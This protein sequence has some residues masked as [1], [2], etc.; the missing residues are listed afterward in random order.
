MHS[1]LIAKLE[2]LDGPSRETDFWI[3]IRCPV[4]EPTRHTDEELQADIDLVGIENMVIDAPY[5]ASLDA[6]IVLVGRMLPG[7][8]WL[9]PA[10][11]EMAV[12]RHGD[13]DTEAVEYVSDH[14]VAAIA[15][16]IAT[17]KAL[18]A[19]DG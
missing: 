2:A 14:P 8:E 16:L 12:Y 5:T 1:D 3:S 4:D 18:E 9:K 17:L 13:G 10:W 15:L 7:W 11:N 6:V 19:W